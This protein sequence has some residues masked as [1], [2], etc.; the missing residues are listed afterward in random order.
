MSPLDPRHKHLHKQV[1]EDVAALWHRTELPEDDDV[2]LAEVQKAG[3][4]PA[5]RREPRKRLAAEKKRKQRKPSRL[6]AVTNI[7]LMHLL[8]TFDGEAPHSID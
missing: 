8:E 7:H 4:Q 1:D 5:Q 3:M 6:R 2:M